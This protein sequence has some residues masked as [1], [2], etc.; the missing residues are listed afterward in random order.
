MLPQSLLLL[1]LLLVRW[2]E[3]TKFALRL[4]LL[5]SRLERERPAIG[6]FPGKVILDNPYVFGDSRRANASDQ[7]QVN[8]GSSLPS[9]P[10]TVEA[11]SSRR[12]VLRIA[13]AE[14]LCRCRIDLTLRRGVRGMIHWRVPGLIV[15]FPR[16]GMK[17]GTGVEG[18][19]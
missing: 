19:R 17:V 5:W 8:R 14:G 7:P 4:A 10:S 11:G 18:C 12:P 3:V 2:E 9:M 16:T 13:G 1:L 15:Q 6:G